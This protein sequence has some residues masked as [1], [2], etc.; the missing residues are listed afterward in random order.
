M[1]NLY[2]KICVWI[3]IW[4]RGVPLTWVQSLTKIHH[5]VLWDKML[6]HLLSNITSTEMAQTTERIGFSPS[7]SPLSPS[8]VAVTSDSGITT[9]P[10]TVSSSTAITATTR[11]EL[12]AYNTTGYVP[13]HDELDYSKYRTLFQFHFQGYDT[14]IAF[15][16]SKVFQALK[17]M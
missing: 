10:D 7:P 2:L 12:H 17:R 9:N 15:K 1:L 5:S 3:I 8:L 16:N 4:S 13:E 11:T 14:W 6:R